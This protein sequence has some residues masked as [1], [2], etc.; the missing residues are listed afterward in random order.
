MAA[1]LL[2][3]ERFDRAPVAL[4]KRRRGPL[5]RGVVSI[6]TASRLK[7]GVLAEV[8]GSRDK[9]ENDGIRVLIKHFDPRT[10]HCWLTKS[11]GRVIRCS[12]GALDTEVWFKPEQL[13]RVWTG[14]STNERIQLRMRRAAS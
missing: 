7:V 6:K 1:N 5:P 13:R 4:P 12:D 2:R 11:L 14:L 8:V 3:H 9:S 10:R